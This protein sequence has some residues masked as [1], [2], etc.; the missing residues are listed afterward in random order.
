MVQVTPFFLV[1]SLALVAPGFSERR[2][3]CILEGRWINNVGHTLVI[4]P[5]DQ[6]GRFEGFYITYRPYRL[7]GFQLGRD[8]NRKTEFEFTV[9]WS[10]DSKTIFKGESFVNMWW[11]KV[12]K[13]TWVLM[14]KEKK[15]WKPISGGTYDFTR[16]CSCRRCGTI[17]DFDADGSTWDADPLS[18]TTTG[19]HSQEKVG[20]A[21]DFE[22]DGC[23]WDADPISGSTTCY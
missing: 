10:S 23:A 18:C 5:L 2:L 13:T 12:L 9:Y 6:Q 17:W 14:S 20:S 8:L 22:T 15:H 4:G 21:G 19:Q 16:L 7:K 11:N 3:R 1:L